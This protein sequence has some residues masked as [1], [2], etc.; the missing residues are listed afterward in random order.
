MQRANVAGMPNCREDS[1]RFDLRAAD[2][3]SGLREGSVRSSRN[4]PDACAASRRHRSEGSVAQASSWRS[5]EADA[6]QWP[7]SPEGAR[8]THGVYGS[9]PL[10]NSFRSR[11]SNRWRSENG[12]AARDLTEPVDR[13]LQ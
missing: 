6:G 12:R 4:E 13:R 3:K 1:T 11:R 2:A 8:T 10:V 9:L 7:T 5:A